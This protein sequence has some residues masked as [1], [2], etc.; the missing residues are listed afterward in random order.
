[1]NASFKVLLLRLKNSGTIMAIVSALIILLTQLGVILDGDKI[2]TTV[3][4]ICSVL[5]MLGVLNNP[6]TPGVY[7]PFV[8]DTESIAATKAVEAGTITMGQV[9][10][11]I[12]DATATIADATTIIA[13][14]TATIA[15]VAPIIEADPATIVG[16]II[17]SSTPTESK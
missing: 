15:S 4:S 14:A 2:T 9:T 12:A 16:Q 6:S 8:Q 13:D 1:M 11:N 7:V 10:N 5:V 3:N 17:I